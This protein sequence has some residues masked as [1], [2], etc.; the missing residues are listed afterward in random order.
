MQERDLNLSIWAIRTPRRP[1]LRVKPIGRFNSRGNTRQARSIIFSGFV[2]V[3]FLSLKTGGNFG[4]QRGDNGVR[5]RGLRGRGAATVAGDA[6]ERG[7][8]V[9]H[10]VL[11]KPHTVLGVV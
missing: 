2:H 5:S 4:L 3:L 11:V 8:A 9:G 10:Y 7:A 6:G 1:T